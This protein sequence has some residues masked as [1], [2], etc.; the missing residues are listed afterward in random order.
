MSSN[1]FYY[2]LISLCLLSGLLAS[3]DNSNKP[4]PPK[5]EPVPAPIPPPLPGNDVVQI[6]FNFNSN[7]D[8]WTAGFADYPIAQASIFNLS[9]NFSQL[10]A[11]L[12]TASGFMVSGT[13]RSDDLFMFIKKRFSG[14]SANTQYQ[15]QFEITFASDAPSGCIGVGGAPGEAVTIKAGA[16]VIEP[17]AIND[18]NNVYI[19]NIDKGNQ[20]V[21]GSDAISIGD[22]ANS[23]ICDNNGFT[24]ELKTLN[25]N[26][27]PF[28]VLTGSDG[29][30][31]FSFS[32]DSGFESTTQIYY[33]GGKIKATK[34]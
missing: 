24:Y 16:S 3:C 14:F 21:G 17:L 4:T 8:G 9:A 7:T 29:N 5:P 20:S 10:P 26:I 33:I 31:W 13:N 1:F 11:P 28:S 15:I 30:L 2:P 25:N 19:M 32:T 27:A 18:G 23:K 6:D 34:I 22:F 12:Q